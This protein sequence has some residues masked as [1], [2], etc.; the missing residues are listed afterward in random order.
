MI[1]ISWSALGLSLL[2]VCLIPVIRLLS[3]SVLPLLFKVSGRPFPLA[4]PE[5]K[6]FWFTGL[7][8]GIIAFALSL[9]I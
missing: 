5:R 9:Q 8:K 3:V 7:I 2:L 1:S 6:L 4:K